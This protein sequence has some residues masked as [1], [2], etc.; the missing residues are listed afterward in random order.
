[1]KFCSLKKLASCNKDFDL[2]DVKV[3]LPDK[4]QLLIGAGE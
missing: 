1:V 2:S 3:T 4:L